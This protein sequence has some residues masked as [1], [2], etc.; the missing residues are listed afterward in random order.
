MFSGKIVKN[1]FQLKMIYL[2]CLSFFKSLIKIYRYLFLSKFLDYCCILKF[3]HL[4]LFLQIFETRDWFSNFE[5]LWILIE[6]K[7]IRNFLSKKKRSGIFFEKKK[8]SGIF[9]EKK[10][11]SGIFLFEKKRSGIFF[12][13][14]PF[15]FFFNIKKAKLL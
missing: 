13:F 10:K 2:I 12:P 3:S 5:R 1:S 6:K 4:G 8:R 14:F 11:R 7:T 9:F 15:N